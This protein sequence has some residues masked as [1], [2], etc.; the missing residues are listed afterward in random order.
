MPVEDKKPE[1]SLVPQPEPSTK[2]ISWSY[3][4]HSALVDGAKEEPARESFAMEPFPGIETAPETVEAQT[5]ERRPFIFGAFDPDCTT[6]FGEYSFGNANTAKGSVARVE[7]PGKS[8]EQIPQEEQPEKQGD[9]ED[10]EVQ[11]DLAV[12]LG[13]RKVSAQNKETSAVKKTA[14]A[15]QDDRE[16][17]VEP[18]AH[19]GKK[20]RVVQSKQNGAVVDVLTGQETQ[21]EQTEELKEGQ[22]QVEQERQEEK[23]DASCEKQAIKQTVV[24]QTQELV[25]KP[26][27]S[28]DK[29]E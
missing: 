28:K 21:V 1:D 17:Q 3:K 24:K 8:K 10:V 16:A 2:T 11:E 13:K 25:E 18:A 23:A 9:Q 27:V 20:E 22:K 14:Q 7:Q 4:T 29:K 6:D 19:P 15:E 5:V 12:Q 26:K